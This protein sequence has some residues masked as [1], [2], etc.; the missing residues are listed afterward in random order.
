MQMDTRSRL[1]PPLSS[2]PLQGADVPVPARARLLAAAVPVAPL[3]R[4]ADVLHPRRRL[5][6]RPE[7]RRSRR[8]LRRPRRT[9]RQGGDDGAASSEFRGEPTKSRCPIL[10][11]G[12][13][14]RFVDA[15]STVLT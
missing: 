12:G 15:S 3:L 13:E 9:L 5:R 2:P 10:T 1:K 14:M 7:D 6:R 11:F 4:L 8:F